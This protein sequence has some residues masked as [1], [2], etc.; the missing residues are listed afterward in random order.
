MGV[1]ESLFAQQLGFTR[2]KQKNYVWRHTTAVHFEQ[3]AMFYLVLHNYSYFASFSG[4][5]VSPGGQ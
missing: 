5:P 2:A 3:K 4:W 1:G